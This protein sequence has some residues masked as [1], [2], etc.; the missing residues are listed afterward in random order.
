L[1]KIWSS[2]IE[3]D[4]IWSRVAERRDLER[5]YRAGEQSRREEI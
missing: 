1:D 2:G 4:E 3:E 5:S